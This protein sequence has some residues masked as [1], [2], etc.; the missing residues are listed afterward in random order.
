MTDPNWTL[1]LL[2]IGQGLLGTLVGG[3]LVLL[4][5][6]LTDRRRTK[7]DDE[8]RYRREQALLTGMFAVRNFIVLRLNEWEDKGNL[9]ALNPLRTAQAY[10]QRIIEKA[11]NESEN[12]MIA[13]VD[14]GLRLDA[15]IAAT[16]EFGEGRQYSF[17][18]LT[19]FA[20][21]LES[22]AAELEQS[23]EQFDLISGRVLPLLSETE[24]AEFVQF[25]T[26]PNGVVEKQKTKGQT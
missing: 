22:R 25:E 23:L 9:E 11:P 18:N 14:I 17:V 26:T 2:K 24:L 19:Q 10:V 1:E 3:G 13:V 5:S 8:L 7:N 12:L 6:W 21:Y 20:V 4:G 16:E 15:L